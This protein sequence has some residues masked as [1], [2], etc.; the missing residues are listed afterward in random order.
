MYTMN[1]ILKRKGVR[2][3]VKFAMVGFSSTV[4]DFSILNVCIKLLSFSIPFA[5][6]WG[7]IFGTTNGY[8]LNNH[9][10]FKDR[11]KSANSRDLT[12]YATISAIGLG[13]TEL[14][15]HQLAVESNIHYNIAK[16]IAVFIVFFWNFFANRYWTFKK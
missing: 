15:M 4:I 16:L 12:K 11:N 5:T 6:F 3:L 9:W 1:K 7:F 14:I 10:T 13:L 2:E 8:F